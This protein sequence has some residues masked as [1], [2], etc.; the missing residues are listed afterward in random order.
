MITI[1]YEMPDTNKVITCKLTTAELQERKAKAIAE[2]KKHVKQVKELKDGYA[3]R[4][5]GTDEMLDQLMEFIKTERQCCGFFTFRLAIAE[6][7]EDVW[8]ELTGPK[9]A[10]E[11]LKNELG[12]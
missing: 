7:N 5:A 3:Y 11:F 8:L 1:H 9:G 4:F 6:E 2:M 12:L 10:K